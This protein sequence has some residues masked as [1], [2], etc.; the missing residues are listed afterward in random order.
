MQGLVLALLAA[1]PKLVVSDFILQGAAP[2]ELSR[3]LSDVAAAEAARVERVLEGPH[4]VVVQKAGFVPWE[5]TI[6]VAASTTVPVSVSL[7]S[8]AAM[9]KPRQA[10]VEVFGGVNLPPR[11]GVVNAPSCQAGCIGNLGGIRGGYLFRGRFALELFLV[12]YTA[13]N[14]ESRRTI[15]VVNDSGPVTSTNYTERADQSATI[16]G[17]L[18]AVRFFETFPLLI[19]FWA[20]AAHGAV[21]T[22][23]SGQFPGAPSDY[24]HDSLSQAYWTAVFGPEVRVGYRLSK[25]VAMDLGVAALYMDVPQTIPDSARAIQDQRVAL[26]EGPAFNGGGTFFY[27][28]TLGLHYDF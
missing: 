19:R 28:V 13:L 24:A 11:Y 25:G 17:F 7:V 22:S 1:A 26:P 27:P 23:A 15:T 16:G 12:P 8:I 3:A 6:M 18:A 2:R 20:G 21:Y 9:E 4:R 14:H 5:G 10:Y